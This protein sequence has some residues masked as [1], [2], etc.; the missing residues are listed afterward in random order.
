MNPSSDSGQARYDSP[1]KLPVVIWRPYNGIGDWLFCLAVAKLLNR[2]RPDVELFV[3]FN[4]GNAYKLPD[5]VPQA[6]ACSDVVYHTG[7]PASAARVTRDSLVY[8]A[9]PPENYIESTV[10]HLNDQTGVGIR[11]ER[12]VFP[13]F[14]VR[15][16]GDGDYVVMIAHGKRR[17]RHRKEWGVANLSALARRLADAGLR[18]VQIGA[19]TDRRLEAADGHVLGAHFSTVADVL[20]GARAYVGLEN[21]I[22]VLAGYLGVPQVTIYDGHSHPCRLDFE[23]HLKIAER[24]EPPAAA[25]RVLAWLD[26]ET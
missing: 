20:A 24:I 9:F 3:D 6:F 10:L 15:H 2:Q 8:R 26:E 13:D 21:G 14:G 1:D 5:L 12:H 25:T 23:R 7:R 4:L 17:E 19:S 11:Y 16:T 22:A 18:V